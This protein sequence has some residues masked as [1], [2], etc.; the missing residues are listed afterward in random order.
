MFLVSIA[1]AAPARA[2]TDPVARGDYLVNR[3]ALCG[4]CHSPHGPHPA[5]ADLSGAPFP[6]A[7]MDPSLASY[8]P[9][10]RGLPGGYTQEGL[11]DLLAT[12]HRPDGSAPR[13][14]MPAFRM[15]PEDAR[16]VAAYLA[17]LTPATP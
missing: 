6:G 2:Q 3:L 11:A 15:A 4:D 5:A 1:V 9:N 7:Q 14:P 13:R 17:S 16:A 12:G 10:L 8:A